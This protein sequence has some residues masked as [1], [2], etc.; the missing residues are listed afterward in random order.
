[1]FEDGVNKL[2]QKIVQSSLVQGKGNFVQ[3]PQL[4]LSL[5]SQALAL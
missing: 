1:M 2:D 5:T 3:Q 4:P